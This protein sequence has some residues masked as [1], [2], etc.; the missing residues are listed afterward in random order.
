MWLIGLAVGCSEWN[1]QADPDPAG[2]TAPAIA[3]ST[4]ALSFGGVPFDQTSR[5]PLVISSVGEAPLT[6]SGLALPPG[7]GFTLDA[8]AALPARLDPGQGIEVEVIYAPTTATDVEML[9]VHSDDPRQPTLGVQL[10][11][12]MWLPSLAI[13]PDP[14]DFGALTVGCTATATATLTSNG[15]VPITV[16]AVGVDDASLGVEAPDGPLSLAP[17]QS[18]AVP[19]SFRPNGPGD[20]VAD[21]WAH[22]DALTPTVRAFVTAASDLP[23]VMIPA[24]TDFGTVMADCEEQRDLIVAIVADCERSVQLSVIGSAFTPGTGFVAAAVVGGS[25]EWAVP[26]AFAPHDPGAAQG[27]LQIV[28]VATGVVGLVELSGTGFVPEQTDTFEVYPPAVAPV[29]LNA[30]STLYTFDPTTLTIDRIGDFGKSFLDIAIDDL[31]VLYGVSGGEIHRIHPDEASTTLLFD[32]TIHGNGLAVLQDGRLLLSAGTG[33]YEVDWLTGVAS[34]V[35]VLPGSSSGD[36]VQADGDLYVTVTGGDELIHV[37]PGTWVTTTVG[38]LGTSS[39]WGLAYYEQM[40]LG[41][42]SSGG[43]L[44]ID[45]ANADVLFDTDF[46]PSWYGAAHTP[47]VNPWPDLTFRLSE[48]P[49]DPAEIRVEVDGVV[50]TD[51]VWLAGSQSIHF[52]DG[53]SIPEGQTVSATYAVLAPCP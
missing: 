8:G 6:V 38:N 13:T 41:F 19:V 47:E 14:V 22:T 24:P 27:T 12:Q 49:L 1:L 39:V 40:L 5:L 53:S 11:G 42:T 25:E 2:S 31:G 23:Q 32:T 46:T 30:S 52:P 28:D 20:V 34:Q 44:V 43:G 7:T 3:L 37:D 16:E 36:V 15:D 29:Y 4:D 50:R 21:L 45:P 33:L 35:A 51:W 48:P 18:I 17:G 26:V 10:T 9:W